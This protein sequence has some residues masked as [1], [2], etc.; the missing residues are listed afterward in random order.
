M[1]NGKHIIYSNTWSNH[2]SFF[3][4]FVVYKASKMYILIGEC[5]MYVLHFTSKSTLALELV[6][7]WDWN[8]KISTIYPC[9]C[10]N[11]N[12]HIK[13]PNLYGRSPKERV[14]YFKYF[15]QSVPP[16]SPYSPR[17]YQD[18]SQFFSSNT[19]RGEYGP[20]LFVY[21]FT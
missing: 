6:E 8:W 10:R 21:F 4:F 15:R 1:S 3:L 11:R 17:D 16:H 13:S 19:S 7:H 5:D 9:Y 2:Y 20:E 14:K 18:P 12:K